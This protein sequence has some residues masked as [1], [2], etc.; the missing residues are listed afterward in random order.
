M[1]TQRTDFDY[2]SDILDAVRKARGFVAGMAFEDFEAD[3][4]T[5]FAVT[6]ALEIVG[7]AAKKITPE[8]RASCPQIPWRDMAAMRDKLTHGYFGV[9]PQVLWETV[10]HD[11]PDLEATVSEIVP[12]APLPN[13]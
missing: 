11:L 4:R 3:S 5:L 13:G 9:S 10:Q 8:L 6:R 2:L 1:S 7:E 12:D